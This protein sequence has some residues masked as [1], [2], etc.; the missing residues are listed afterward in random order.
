MD[1]CHGAL[2]PVDP[3]GCASARRGLVQKSHTNVRFDIPWF[4]VQAALEGRTGPVQLSKP[5]AAHT[6][7]HAYCW[8]AVGTRPQ[9]RLVDAKGFSVLLLIE[10]VGCSDE[11]RRDIVFVSVL[12]IL[13]NEIRPFRRQIQPALHQFK[14]SLVRPRQGTLVVDLVRFLE[15]VHDALTNFR[16]PLFAL[17]HR[18]CGF[19]QGVG[20]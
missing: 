17:I 1:A 6:D 4:Q 14:E 20:S 11:L 19:K 15:V 5:G 16:V 18:I 3:V 13:Q 8:V 12:V 2:E 9:N 7:A 10:L